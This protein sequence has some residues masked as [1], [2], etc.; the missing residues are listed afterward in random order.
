M[1]SAALS[2]NGL[3][4]DIA[5]RFRDH[6]IDTPDLDARILV[7]HA[8]GLSHTALMCAGD[9]RL[10]AA[11][12]AR[13]EMLAVRRLAREPV[14]RITGIK[15]FWG[16]PLKVTPAVLVPRPET[17]TVIEQALATLDQTGARSGALRIADLGVGSGAIMIAL[18][19]EL[20]DACAIGT[21]LDPAALAVARENARR[22]G[23][24][25]RAGFVACNFGA[26]LAPGYDLVVT[27]PPY[28][29]TDEIAKLEP[30]VGEFDPRRALDGGLDG[31]AAYRTIAVDGQRILAPGAHL[32]AEIGKGQS[33]AVVALFGAAGFGSMKIVP[34]LAGIPRV[35]VASRNP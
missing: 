27:N 11:E 33:D 24:A 10:Q 1:S 14:A 29:R 12:I 5:R 19:T 8:L 15:E 2:V 7:G 4:R 35:V 18:L 6:G 17:E 25:T 16:L 22:L 31:V 30:E 32:I 3:R 28:I 21:D 34:D 26:G 20:S 9:R 23:V 13:I